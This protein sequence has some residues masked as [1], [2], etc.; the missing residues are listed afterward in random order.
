MNCKDLESVVIDLARDQMMEVSLREAA[1]S[2]A[3]SC[4]SCACRLQDARAL[5]AGLRRVAS[6]ECGEAP[7]HVEAALIA[8]FRAHHHKSP[9]L[10]VGTRIATRRWLYVAASVAAGAVIVIWV[11]LM[12]SG[13]RHTLPPVQQQTADA[14]SSQPSS[15]PESPQAVAA[16]PNRENSV[17]TNDKKGGKQRVA[18]G[19]HARRLIPGAGDSEPLS[20]EVEIATDFFPLVNSESLTELDSGQLVRVELPRSALM[21]FGLPMSMDRVN[22]RVKADVV[23]GNDGL[24]RAIRFVR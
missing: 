3:A 10:T 15:R 9:R 18:K 19:N 13:T 5:T 20:P 8:A 14:P 7:P 6:A 17:V 23:V 16:T 2:H 12:V 4:A 11:S 22:E 1:L 24:A 21:S